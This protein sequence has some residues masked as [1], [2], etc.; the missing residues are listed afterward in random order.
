MQDADILKALKILGNSIFSLSDGDTEKCQD[1]VFQL[2]EVV[3]AAESG[4]GS[5]VAVD[6]APGAWYFYAQELK[7][8]IER[9]HLLILEEIGQRTKVSGR[10]ELQEQVS[11]ALRLPED[12]GY[13]SPFLAE[14]E[15]ETPSVG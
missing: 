4:A 12:D 1:Q 5:E 11:Q 10:K 6:P 3:T 15:D 7:G 8:I 2:L 9:A 13:E 14:E